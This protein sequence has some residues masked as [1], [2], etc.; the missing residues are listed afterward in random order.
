MVEGSGGVAVPLNADETISDVAARYELETILVVGLR[1]GCI[2]HALLSLEYLRRRGISVL[3]AVLCETRPSDDAN[4]HQDVRRILQDH[5]LI[6]DTI[7]FAYDTAECV[8]RQRA[9][10]GLSRR[11]EQRLG[12]ELREAQK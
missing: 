2:N 7:F 8:E 3:G 1:L 5:C 9:Q 4:Y 11:R 12:Q 6:I 10:D